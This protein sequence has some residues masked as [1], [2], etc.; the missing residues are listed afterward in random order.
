MA[1]LFYLQ[2]SGFGSRRSHL[3][4]QN[5]V[6]GVKTKLI[7]VERLDNSA[8]RKVYLTPKS[9]IRKRN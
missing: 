9:G 8:A 2:T 1:A 4:L 7:A 5:T 3:L 6:L